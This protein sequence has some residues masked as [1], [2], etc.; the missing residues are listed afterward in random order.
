MLESFVYLEP[1]NEME[2]EKRKYLENLI[3]LSR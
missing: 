3:K 2:I 1:A